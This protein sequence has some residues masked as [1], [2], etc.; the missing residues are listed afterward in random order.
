METKGWTWEKQ[1]APGAV[2]G[3]QF[4]RALTSAAWSDLVS[5]T[6]SASLHCPYPPPE[7]AKP[8]GAEEGAPPFTLS[9]PPSYALQPVGPVLSLLLRMNQHIQASCAK[10]GEEEILCQLFELSL[11]CCLHN[12]KRYQ[13]PPLFSFSIRILYTHLEPL[14]S[15]MLRWWQPCPRTCEGLN[16]GAQEG[17]T[18]RQ[19]KGST[20][21]RCPHT[22]TRGTASAQ[23]FEEEIETE[24]DKRTQTQ[25]DVV[26][27]GSAGV[28]S[29]GLT[30]PGSQMT[31]SSVAALQPPPSW[32]GRAGE[33]AACLPACPPTC[34]STAFEGLRNEWMSTPAREAGAG[35]SHSESSSQPD[36][37]RRLIC[38]V[39]DS[40]PR[41]ITGVQELSPPRMLAAALA[42]SVLNETPSP[43]DGSSNRIPLGHLGFDLHWITQNWQSCRESSVTGLMSAWLLTAPPCPHSGTLERLSQLTQF[44]SSSLT[45]VQTQYSNSFEHRSLYLWLCGKSEQIP[46]DEG[47]FCSGQIPG[48]NPV[49]WCTKQRERLKAALTHHPAAM[50]NGN[51]NTMGHM[52][53]MMSSRQ[54]QTPHHHMHSHPHQHQ[55]LPPHHS[56]PHQHQHPAHHPHPQP[57]HQQN[58]PHHHSHSHLH[59]HP[60]HHQ[61]SPHPPLHSGGQAQTMQE[62]QQQCELSVSNRIHGLGS[63]T[64]SRGR[65]KVSPEPRSLGATDRQESSPKAYSQGVEH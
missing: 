57:H 46:C 16:R 3:A 51:M 37:R 40:E 11:S 38:V 50:S 43:E 56:Y 39:K 15:K 26:I 60:A 32:Q 55:T 13:A 24:E 27:A 2:G 8:S 14:Q 9:A 42:V 31:W 61:T 1:T 44:V 65:E 30:C 21:K 19:M 12:Y 23:Y 36:S 48:P 17:F 34:L 64:P 33:G 62:W 4:T 29:G 18:R 63:Q 22:H 6:C 49:T 7:S 52:M 10:A 58:H 59:A 35:C 41:Q 25:P 45:V 20:I 28:D 47:K 5:W 54:D 53:E